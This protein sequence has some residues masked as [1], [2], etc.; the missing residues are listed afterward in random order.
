[1]LGPYLVPGYRLIQEKKNGLFQ[2]QVPAYNKRLM[3]S[4]VPTLE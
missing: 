2:G 1:M 3:S 4:I